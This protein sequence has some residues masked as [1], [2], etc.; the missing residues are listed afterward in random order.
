M[1]GIS[2]EQQQRL[3]DDNF[4]EIFKSNFFASSLQQLSAAGWKPRLLYG[5]S[6]PH[7]TWVLGGVTIYTFAPAD[8]GSPQWTTN[9]SSPEGKSFPAAEALTSYIESVVGVHGCH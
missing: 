9:Q 6:E 8:M 5:T 3:S 2:P 1:Q 7:L 4:G